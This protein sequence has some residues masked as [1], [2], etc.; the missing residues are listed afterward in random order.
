MPQSVYQ[1]VYI[2]R[3]TRPLDDIELGRLATAAKHFNDGH[4]ITGLLLHDG[5]RFIQA[6]EGRRAYVERAMERIARDRRHDSIAFVERRPVPARQFGGWSMDVRRIHDRQ[7][8]QPFLTDL[9]RT[10]ATVDDHRLVAAF[11]GFAMLGRP[12]MRARRPHPEA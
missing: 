6:L 8:A 4:A 9:K 2:S 7:S 12:G 11:I 10:L 5:G 1:L 3:A